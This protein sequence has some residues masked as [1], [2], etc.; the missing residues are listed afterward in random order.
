MQPTHNT[1]SEDIR[2][3]SI[4]LLNEHLAASIDLHSQVKQAH[5][6]VRGPGFFAVHELFDKVAGEVASFSDIIAERVGALGGEAHGTIQLAS[7]RSFLIPYEHGLADEKS[8]LYAVAG[9]LAAF[10][11]SVR[12]AI[13][14]ADKSGD[15]NT[16]DIFTEV[17]R[18]I[19]KQL[20]FVESHIAPAPRA[21]VVKHAG[22]KRA[23]A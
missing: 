9:S 5:W 12:E 7:K 3:Q 22:A 15:A 23:S 13:D 20:W 1:L 11:Q 21:A 17:S 10:G 8:H 16:A 14:L 18:G 19:D 6:N 4:E 2:A